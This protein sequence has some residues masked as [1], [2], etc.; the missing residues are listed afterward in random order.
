LPACR[1]EAGRQTDLKRRAAAK[2]TCLTGHEQLADRVEKLGA[3]L[4]DTIYPTLPDKDQTLLSAQVGA[5]SAYLQILN[6]RLTRAT[7]D[8]V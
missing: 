3:F 6:L 1:F 7:K 4:T 2:G 5:M 8:A